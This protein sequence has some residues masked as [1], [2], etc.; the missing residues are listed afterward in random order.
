MFLFEGER[1]HFS[2]SSPRSLLAPSMAASVG[3]KSVR[4]GR[5][6]LKNPARLAAWTR[7]VSTVRFAEDATTCSIVLFEESIIPSMICTRPFFD[8]QAS[9]DLSS[10]PLMNIRWENNKEKMIL[11]RNLHVHVQLLFLHVCVT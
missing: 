5:G 3:A 7:E 9:L 2:R 6:L 4:S 1:R 11:M 10:F 8:M